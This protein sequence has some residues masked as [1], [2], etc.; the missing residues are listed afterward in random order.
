MEVGEVTRYTF[1]EV[2]DALH[3]H[4]GL[5]LR[6]GAN[7]DDKHDGRWDVAYSRTG[8]IVVGQLPGLGYGHMHYATLRKIVEH[9]DLAAVIERRR[10]D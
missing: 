10:A 7:Y 4:W 1:V 8:F 5:A 6:R 2:R 3:D 9:C